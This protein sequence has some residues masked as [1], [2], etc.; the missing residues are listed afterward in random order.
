MVNQK[1]L[2]DTFLDLV[3]IDSP[4][5]EESEITDF[6][7]S[8]LTQNDLVDFVTKDRFGNIYARL[9]GDGEPIFFS[10]HLDTVEPGRTIQPRINGDY[11]TSA[12]DTILGA[13]DKSSV[14][15]V[16]EMLHGIKENNIPHHPVELMFTLS[17]EVGNLGAINFDYTLLQAKKG[18][19]FDCS[20]PLGTLVIAS[21]FY[22]R[23][24]IKLIGKTA[25]ASRPDIGKSIIPS[26]AQ[27][28]S[29]LNLGVI[30]PETIL[31][32][33]VINSGHVRN[34]I[35]GEVTLEGEIRSFSEQK[36]MKELRNMKKIIAVAAKNDSV[37][38]T[39]ESVRENPGFKL[40]KREIQL[41]LD[42]LT[43]ILSTLNIIPNPVEIWSVSDTN[44]FA[45]HG[46]TCLN[47]GSGR[48]FAHT[49]NE[50]IKITTMQEL[51]TIMIE[52]ARV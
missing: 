14:A 52:L 3:K 1:R 35:P 12:G 46:L 38:Y 40:S 20:W 16:L 39:F 31:N 50:R 22:E 9:E 28:L 4:T 51:S 36:L 34:A 24:T 44:I 43:P 29:T 18:Y 6:V 8:Y 45:T 49:K 42:E 26:L 27:L 25:H 32:I 37:E 19:C 47:L 41:S 15:C 2:V 17:E 23:F 11:I 7:I 13:D 5:G 30:D 48:E 10:E 33:G 21:P